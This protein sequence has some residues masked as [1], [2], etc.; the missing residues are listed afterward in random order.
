MVICHNY[1]LNARLPSCIQQNKR[2]M[3]TINILLIV[4]LVIAIPRSDVNAQSFITKAYKLSIR[5]TSSLHDWESTV[6]KMEAKGSFVLQNNSLSDVRDVQ[7]LIPV[8]AIKSSKGKIM[9]NKT[10]EAF[11][12][13]KNPNIKFILTNKKIDPVRSTLIATGTLTMAGITKPIELHILYKVLSEGELL[14]SGSHTLQMTDYKMDPPTA[15]MG[16]IQVGDNVVV[17]FE[18]TLTA[19]SSL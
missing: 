1:R 9:D 4:A 10:W 16:A 6:D 5:G 17:N 3:K 7:V 8:K 14:I 11:N 18:M 12:Y 15:M 19:N 2:H 13:E